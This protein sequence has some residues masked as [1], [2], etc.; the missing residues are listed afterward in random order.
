M[1]LGVA[2][3]LATLVN[4]GG[5]WVLRPSLSRGFVKAMAI[6]L[7][8]VSHACSSTVGALV[9]IALFE[10]HAIEPITG[11]KTST[12]NAVLAW[13]IVASTGYVG[14]VCAEL[15][16]RDVFIEK[17]RDK[18]LGAVAVFLSLGI[19]WMAFQR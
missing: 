3:L 4:F 15:E 14:Y 6:L 9:A 7:E 16:E 5:F 2:L 19:I 13:F 17:V 8:T 11:D 12:V 1:M 18:L 10:H